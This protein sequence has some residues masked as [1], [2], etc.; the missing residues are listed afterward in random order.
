MKNG[1]AITA[2][3]YYSKDDN[4]LTQELEELEDKIFSLDKFIDF[5]NI[6]R[7]HFEI[8]KNY[9]IKFSYADSL[10]MESLVVSIYKLFG[11]DADRIM[12]SLSFKPSASYDKSRTVIPGY[13]EAIYIPISTYL[14]IRK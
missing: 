9:D 14:E 6:A 3:V 13:T 5:G 2:S 12:D 8:I 1:G 10:K 11:R 7:E 4:D